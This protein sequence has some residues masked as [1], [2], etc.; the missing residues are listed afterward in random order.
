MANDML[1]QLAAE[2]VARHGPPRAIDAA[3]LEAAIDANPVALRRALA[4][5]NAM[6]FDLR[7]EHDVAAEAL[8]AV[9]DAR[10]AW[11]DRLACVRMLL[12]HDDEWYRTGRPFISNGQVALRTSSSGEI[13]LPILSCLDYM[14]FHTFGLSVL[15]AAARADSV[16]VVLELVKRGADAT[17]SMELDNVLGGGD[18]AMYT[19]L[20][21]AARHGNIE[22]MTVLMKYGATLQPQW[23]V[24][25]HLPAISP[26]RDGYYPAIPVDALSYF[27]RVRSAGG[28]KRYCELRQSGASAL[29]S[30]Y[31]PEEIVRLVFGFLA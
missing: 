10:S 17:G 6:R 15:C 7:A 13:V 1:A 16:E 3:L 24:P 28:F 26:Y 23:R 27:D 20:E 30:R 18:Y 25:A 9:I 2:R 8:F 22:T 11:Q 19:P 5:A 14:Y 31:F 4:S 29:L 21:T 12:K